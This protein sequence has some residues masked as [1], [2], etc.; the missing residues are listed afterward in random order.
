[1]TEVFRTIATAVG[2]IVCLIL[3]WFYIRNGFGGMV[4]LGAA[5]HGDP[6]ISWYRRKAA[7]QWVVMVAAPL[8]A[9][10]LSG[11]LFPAFDP[12]ALVA[13]FA[14][15]VFMA[16]GLTGEA[17]TFSLDWGPV[18]GVASLILVLELIPVLRGKGRSF[19]L[20]NV[21]SLLPRNMREA[22]W[23]AVLSLGAG[24]GEEL[25]FR[26]LIPL[27]L[28]ALGVPIVWGFL[29][30]CVLF[31]ACHTY[32]G[33]VGV[34]ATG[35]LGLVLAAAY[36]TTFSLWTAIVLHILIDLIGLVVRPLVGLGLE[37]SWR[38]LRSD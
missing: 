10:S 24:F 3:L 22:R 15:E 28:A 14:Y 13:P 37:R 34:L 21:G 16:T 5:A 19:M 2:L 31:A 38:K 33:W 7:E 17:F 36:A 35:V 27:G 8:V 25:L 11:L 1:M 29:I 18:L 26:A 6:R 12:G 30:S 4:R 9:L 23:T 20:G 32:Q